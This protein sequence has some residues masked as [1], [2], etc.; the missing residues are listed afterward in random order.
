MPQDKDHPAVWRCDMQPV[1]SGASSTI[2]WVGRAGQSRDPLQ[3]TI[4]AATA[5]HVHV[6]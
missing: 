6:A 2:L 4:L 3:S 1:C 5:D